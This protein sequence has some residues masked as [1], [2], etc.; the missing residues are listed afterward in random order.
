MTSQHVLTVS[1]PPDAGL[2]DRSL[3]RP[4]PED[5]GHQ[6]AAAAVR[7]WRERAIQTLACE[8]GGLVIV[9]PIWKLATGATAAESIA[10]LV[11]LSVAVM[12][13]MAVYN[14]AFDVVESRLA[15]R[16]A[17]D[18]P[19]CWRVVHAVGLEVSAVLITWP[20][21]MVIAGFGWLEALAADL[22]L[23]AVYAIY[24]YLFHRAFDRLRPVLAPPPGAKRIYP[25]CDSGPAPWQRPVE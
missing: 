1:R 11:C 22:G 16:A 18:R 3:I 19:P 20:L 4:S 14:T 5:A 23:T 13:W 6:P 10:L 8:F 17:S 7:S 9:A 15:G 21:I 2:A 24:G 25:Q 12:S